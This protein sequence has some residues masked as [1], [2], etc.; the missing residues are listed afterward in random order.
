MTEE[1]RFDLEKFFPKRIFRAITDVRVNRPEVVE[2]MALAREQ[3]PRLTYDGRLI[4]IATD[5]PARGVTVSGGQPLIMGNRQEYLGRTL[6]VITSTEF[7]GVM[8]PPDI[9]DDLFIMDYLVQKGGGPSFLNGKVLVGCMQRGGVADVAGEI[10]D[11]FTN[12]TAEEMAALRL[13]G[14]KMMFR[15]LRDDP[16]TIETIWYCSQAVNELNDYGL[17]PFVEP[18]P[19]KGELGKY[20]ANN[21][22]EELVRLVGVAAALGY[23]SRNTWLKVPVIDDFEKVAMATTLPMLM[24]GGASRGDPEPTIHSFYHGLQ[25]GENVRG[26]MVGRNVLFPGAEDPRAVAV[27]INA[28]IHEGL[29]PE[30]AIE[31]MHE[32]RDQDMDFL[33]RYIR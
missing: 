3:R 27:A 30:Q 22:V 17:T 8:G 12:Y 28:L 32:R 19:M 29:T 26:A 20:Q 23:A 5:H 21:T 4:I 13:D 18:L 16:G 15:V 33:V 10:D 1:Y 11:R 31:R 6:R 25:S 9:I 24:L 14:G 2:E 7:D